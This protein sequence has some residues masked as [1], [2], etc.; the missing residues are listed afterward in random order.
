MAQRVLLTLVAVAV[1]AVLFGALLLLGPDEQRPGESTS[2]PIPDAPYVPL[3]A[4]EGPGRAGRGDPLSQVGSASQYY[5][6]RQTGDGRRVEFLGDTYTPLPGGES[7]IGKPIARVELGNR[8]I[9]EI[10]ADE[11]RLVE[12]DRQPQYG[13]LSGDVRVAVY[14]ARPGRPVRFG[15]DSPDATLRVY[16]DA[17]VQFDLLA[18]RLDSD[19]PVHVTSRRFDL[20]GRGLTL[21]YNE[22]ADRIEY[23]ELRRGDQL[24]LRLGRGL[25]SGP[26]A[27]AADGTANTS[28]GEE[29]DDARRGASPGASGFYQAR[30]E[31]L[32][33]ITRL[34]LGLTGDVLD[35]FFNLVSAAGADGSAREMA[36]ES[37]AVT[38][39]DAAIASPA[40]L[41]S[42]RSMLPPRAE[43]VIITWAGRLHVAPLAQTAAPH[44]ADDVLLRLTGRPMRLLDA[45]REL[46]TAAV[47]EYRTASGQID[48][49]GREALPVLVESPSLGLL[50]CE[51]LRVSATTARGTLWGPGRVLARGGRSSGRQGRATT[52]SLRATWSDRMEVSFHTDDPVDG[53]VHRRARNDPARLTG[54]REAT[55]LGEATATHPQAMLTGDS[56]SLRLGEPAADDNEAQALEQ[57][58][59]TGSDDRPGRIQSLDP[60]PG[61]AW[62]V[63]GRTVTVDWIDAPRGTRPS[64][65]LAEGQAVVRRG[66]T[67]LLADE[68]RVEFRD[69]EPAGSD[70]TI[71][72]GP[73]VVEKS[74]AQPTAQAVPPS[75]DDMGSALSRR[76]QATGT[77]FGPPAEPDSPATDG[78]GEPDAT[79]GPTAVAET[80][81]GAP[82]ADA[83]ARGVPRGDAALG[84][85]RLAARGRVT[86]E[87]NDRGLVLLADRLVADEAAGQ[88][89]LFGGDDAP[90]RAIAASQVLT[91]RHMV[92][93]QTTRQLHV[94]GEGTLSVADLSASGLRASTRNMADVAS[95]DAEAA[96]RLEVGWREAMHYDHQSGRATFAGDVR[97]TSGNDA[98]RTQL[99]CEHLALDLVEVGE[100][101]RTVRAATA[102][103][104]AANGAGPAVR[105]VTF[106]HQRLTSTAQPKVASRL[107][108]SGP[109]LTFDNV[110]EQVQVLGAGSLLVEDYSPPPTAERAGRRGR[111]SAGGTGGP[112]VILRGRGV[113]LLTWDG[114]MTLDAHHND[115]RAVRNVAMDHVPPQPEGAT[116]ASTQGVHLDCQHLL[117]DLEPTGGLSVWLSGSPPKPEI[118]GI[119]A[120]NQVRVIA[121]GRTYLTDRMTYTGVDRTVIL[122][123]EADGRGMTEIQEGDGRALTA[124]Q[125]RW[126]L[127]RNTYEL[128]RP[129]PTRMPLR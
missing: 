45:G 101:A 13:T 55:L 72:S 79:A 53:A 17:P 26:V 91:G 52:S 61:Q 69:A 128:V 87:L 3:A 29:P 64:Q 60:R 83:T 66:D 119:Y 73:M 92:L 121:G 31:R 49:V 67:R 23:L 122:R 1:A 10:V 74:I 114:Q 78:Q 38:A 127:A 41:E 32:E 30:F 59:V 97:L 20:R 90:A 102:R 125:V 50:E 36:A 35:V 95:H 100:G 88:V 5:I 110:V 86:A 12:Q 80:S 54:L 57:I 42:A 16:L 68:V 106:F 24:R 7:L 43:D 99:T 107:R 71:A 129:G 6:Q 94:V 58:R 39:T 47:G 77:L 118:R 37:E 63:R 123:G 18:G 89:E 81:T 112:E 44:D 109:V 48:L 105:P 111:D 62:D 75:S 85:Q 124:R 76:L 108:L 104:A 70:A 115:L 103:G 11:A 56:L 14:E 9:V 4:P 82:P 22:L 19:G 117:A 25:G 96:P 98:D 126:D 33:R 15:L 84:L 120:D 21:R 65:L 8:R 27:Q 93:E 46:V 40:A 116:G 28:L 34:D 2:A 51:H 113:T